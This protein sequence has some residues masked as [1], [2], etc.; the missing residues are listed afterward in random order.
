V[1]A[2]YCGDNLDIVRRH[3]GDETVA[4]IYLDP[5]FMT[6]KPHNTF[7]V[8]RR[9][10]KTEARVKAFEDNWR[11][12]ESAAGACEAIIAGGPPALSK[13]MQAFRLLCGEGG[14]LAY[15]TMMAPRLVEFQRALR[16]GGALYLHC[17]GA[18]S[19]YLKVLLDAV[20][21]PANFRNE[22]V[23]TMQ[24]I[25]RKRR[26]GKFPV[27]TQVL[28]YYT[29]SGPH[30]FNEQTWTAKIAKDFKGGRFVLPRGFHR[31]EAGR[32]YWT[33]P[34]GDYT[35]ESVERLRA[36]GRIHVTGRGTVRIKYFVEEDETSLS[37]AR[38][39]TNSWRDIHDTLR[40]GSERLGYPTQKPEAL[41]ERVI[42]AS[43]NEGDLV[44]DPFCGSG[45][46]LAVAHR[47][48]RRWIGIDVSPLAVQLA[49]RR[50]GDSAGA[51]QLPLS[52]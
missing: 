44:L 23:W 48:G 7:I 43:S 1:N 26:I 9:G 38:A 41:L 12:S 51:D 49:R 18:A 27:D 8:T 24:G 28:L 15:L 34:R 52:P 16:P 4:L 32:V 17:D 35:D 36:E 42:R 10:S 20:F 40:N 33:S 31:D 21:S 3:V 5:P 13:A 22:I 30:V 6:N 46:T 50:L 29:K 39:V 2:L 19:H 37:I 25:G 14:L 45:T 11:W 47:L